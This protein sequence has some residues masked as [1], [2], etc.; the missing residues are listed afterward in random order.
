M[1]INVITYIIVDLW[2]NTEVS[3]HHF[4][5]FIIFIFASYDYIR[6]ATNHI[7]IINPCYVC[8]SKKILKLSKKRHDKETYVSVCMAC[9]VLHLSWMQ[10]TQ[11]FIVFITFMF[12]ATIPCKPIVQSI[13][14]L[15][16]LP[17]CIFCGFLL[18]I[19]R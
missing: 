15:Y 10:C 3:C 12:K 13:L 11:I 14:I 6:L 4:L 1:L 18:E 16:N 19:N 8:I 7:N 9:V 5:V 17:P 2:R